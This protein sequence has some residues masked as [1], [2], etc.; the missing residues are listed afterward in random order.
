MRRSFY[1][2]HNESD[3]ATVMDKLPESVP[4][5]FLSFGREYFLRFFL[6]FDQIGEV[7]RIFFAFLF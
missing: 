5:M 2:S 3:S 4:R 1:E 7:E 6:N